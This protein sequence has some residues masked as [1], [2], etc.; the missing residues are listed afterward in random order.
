[1]ASRA[2]DTQCNKGADFIKKR[3]EDLAGWQYIDRRE[4]WVREGRV[5]PPPPQPPL[6]E[7]RVLDSKK[8]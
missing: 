7:P 3:E 4:R 1:M 8:K 6:P 2:H 5:G